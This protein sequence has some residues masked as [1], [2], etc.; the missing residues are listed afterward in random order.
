MALDPV[1]QSR[2]TRWRAM[3]ADGTITITDMREA[4]VAL[5]MGRKSAV[6]ASA[7]SRASRSKKPTDA[8][9]ADMLG[10]LEDL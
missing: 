1:L 3:A 7:T 4:V 10:A 2:L 5:R 6:E 8:S 9:V